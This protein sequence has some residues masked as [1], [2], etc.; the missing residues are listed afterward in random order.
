MS[1]TEQSDLP[2]NTGHILLL[3]LSIVIMSIF[4]SSSSCNE[5]Q[6]TASL[7]SPTA[8]PIANS[9]A[10]TG[11][12]IQPTVV[13]RVTQPSLNS[14]LLPT[15]RVTTEAYNQPDGLF[16]LLVPTNWSL[17]ESQSS[18]TFSDPQ[19]ETTLTVRVVNTVYAL[20]NESFRRLVE[21]REKNI[22]AGYESYTEIDRPSNEAMG[23][24]SIEKQ[25]SNRGVPTSVRSLYLMED[26][27]IFILDFWAKQDNFKAYQEVLDTIVK[28]VNVHP[29]SVSKLHDYSS[30]EDGNYK[31]RYFT[32]QVPVYWEN[33][34]TSGENSVVDTF[35]SPDMRS[36]VQMV[37]YDDGESLSKNVAGDLVRT[38]LREQYARDVTVTSDNLLKDGRERLIW[39][40]DLGKYQ[41]VTLFETRNTALL[42]VTAMWNNDFDEYFQWLPDDI[43]KTYQSSPP[44]TN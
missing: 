8:Q 16:N 31:N 15:I 39:R 30:D 37:I 11:V 40:S 6:P 12:Q 2:N 13:Y 41:G 20:D 4:L 17:R 3:A 29:D 22:Y 35:Y 44:S 23:S 9:T 19:G 14:T 7:I 38:L 34:R 32:I 21:T 28:S 25:F 26:Q 43:I 5:V 42:L 18:S 27:A 10:I 36:A 24:I 1:K 33:K